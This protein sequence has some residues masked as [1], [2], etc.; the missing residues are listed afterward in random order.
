MNYLAHALLARTSPEILVGGLMADFVKGSM[1]VSLPVEIQHGII[2]H[3]RIDR[4]T[5][6]HEVVYQCKRLISPLRRRYAG[7]MVDIFFDHFLAQYWHRYAPD[8]L[9]E[10]TAGVYETLFDH[11]DLL[12]GR[13]QRVLPHMAKDDWLASYHH[14]DAIHNSINGISRNRLKRSNPLLDGAEELEWHYSSFES[15]FNYFFPQLIEF[16]RSE[17]GNRE[18]IN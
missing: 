9:D 11:W 6:D 16:V 15:Y 18:E 17:F 4:F 2:M 14:I 12:P 8:P 10:F 7:V 5:D 3:R 13:L 1:P